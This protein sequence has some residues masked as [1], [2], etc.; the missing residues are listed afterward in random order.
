MKR[1]IIKNLGE[2]KLG[3][4]KLNF[5]IVAGLSY[6]KKQQRDENYIG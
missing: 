3:T 5:T 4:N 2:K 1:I 6:Q